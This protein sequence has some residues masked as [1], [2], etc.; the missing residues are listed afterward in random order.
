MFNLAIVFE[1]NS[2]R[3]S[4]MMAPQVNKNDGQVTILMEKNNKTERVH[5]QNLGQ[6]LNL[7]VIQ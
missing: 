1:E 3:V 6:Q 5:L 7:K 4:A 2:G